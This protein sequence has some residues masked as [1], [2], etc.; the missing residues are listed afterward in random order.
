MASTRYRPFLIGVIA[1]MA[2]MFIVLRPAMDRVPPQKVTEDGTLPGPTITFAQTTE[3]LPDEKNTITVFQQVAPAVVFITN[4]ALQRDFFTLDVQEIPRG[5]GSGFVWDQ[6]GHI[7]TNYHVI[8]EANSLSVKFGDQS[9]FEA[10]VIGAEPNKDIAV[11]RVKAPA[12][13]LHPVSVGSSDKL[14]TGQKVVAIGNPFGLDQTL[15]V[16]VVSALGREIQSVTERTIRD[17]IQTDA[18]INPGNSG[19]PLLDSGGR[20]IGMNTAIVSPSGAYAGIGFAVPVNAIKSVVPQLIQHGKIVRPGLGVGILSDQVA[21]NAGIEGVIIG[22][23]TKGSPAEKA[24]LRG[25]KRNW[26][27][28]AELGDVIVAIDGKKVTNADEL[29][30]ELEKHKVGDEVTLTI[31]REDKEEKAKVRLQPIS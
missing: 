7:V 20:L 31:L 28:Q 15:T 14:L 27:G 11:I 6:N 30:E 24:G 29:A 23:V 26:R 22:S 13:K 9:T 10:D 8:A 18:A 3:L 25:V 4:N 12:N 1:G 17:V 21:K 5:S 19:G 2:V 16:G